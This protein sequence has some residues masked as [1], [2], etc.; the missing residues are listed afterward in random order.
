MH[1]V[2]HMYFCTS[3][4]G[5][6]VVDTK[7]LVD[8]IRKMLKGLENEAEAQALAKILDRDGDGKVTVEGKPW[9]FV[10]LIK[11]LKLYLLMVLEI[12]ALADEIER[13]SN[14]TIT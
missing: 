14:S 3:L 11:M 9:K 10:I 6:G 1:D 13:T 5:D 4:D 2:I 7:E 8:A 12:L